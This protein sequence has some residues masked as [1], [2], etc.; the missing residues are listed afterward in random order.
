MFY[1]ITLQKKNECEQINS[2]PSNITNV[3]ESALTGKTTWTIGKEF[4]IE[5]G[6]KCKR[7]QI[8]LVF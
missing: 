6:K 8:Y 5:L 2:N 1:Y 3:D 4:K 7:L